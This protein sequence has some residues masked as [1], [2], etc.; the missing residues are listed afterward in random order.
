MKAV[1]READY[2]Q[3]YVK[4]GGKDAN[5]VQVSKTDATSQTAD[6]GYMDWDSVAMGLREYVSNA[7]DAAVL[8]NEDEWALSDHGGLRTPWDGVRIEIVD[9]NRVRAKAG[10]TRVFVPLTNEKLGEGQAVVLNFYNTLGK[11]F[12]HFSEPS[13]ITD[14]VSIL[15]KR[16]RNIGEANT[17]VIYRRGVRVREIDSYESESIF[18]YNLNDLRMDESRNVDDYV[19]RCAAAKEMAKASSGVLAVMFRSFVSAETRWEW[20]FSSCELRPGYYDSDEQARAKE[21]AWGLALAGL[22]SNAVLIT[23]DTPKD[24]LISKGYVPVEAPEAFVRAGAAYGILTAEKVLNEDERSGREIV[25]ATMDAVRAV[26]W[27]WDRIILV[28]MSGG[29]EKPP[30]KCF[31]SQMDGGSIKM[32][33]YRDGVVYISEDYASGAGVELRQIALE[34]VAHYITGSTD[35]SR[36][37][38]DFAFKFATRSLME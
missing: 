10:H 12:L 37:F 11:W 28:G 7:L 14:G 17:A 38:Q 21:E 30:V 9:E 4:H 24:V 27:V 8:V 3:I 1:K 6:Y 13:V 22:G 34:E 25:R 23:A 15:P 18:D 29:K 31:R 35:N 5:G 32:G 16:G 20:G 33:F 26:D 2:D 19:C 36:D